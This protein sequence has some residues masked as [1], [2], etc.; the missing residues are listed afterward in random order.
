MVYQFVPG[1][2]I[3]G[4]DKM[5]GSSTASRSGS[6]KNAAQVLSEDAENV[7]LRRRDNRLIAVDKQSGEGDFTS[8]AATFTIFATN[9]ADSMIYA[10]TRDGAVCGDPPGAARRGSRDVGDGHDRAKWKTANA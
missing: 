7:Y 6:S 2:G 4:I 5:Q 8:K 3:V 1:Q 9:P 10:S